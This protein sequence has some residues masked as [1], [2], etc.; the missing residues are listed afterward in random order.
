MDSNPRGGHRVNTLLSQDFAFPPQQGYMM[1]GVSLANARSCTSSITMF[2]VIE[3]QQRQTWHTCSLEVSV[4][5]WEL[6]ARCVCSCQN[7]FC[8]ITEKSGVSRIDTTLP[9]NPSSPRQNSGRKLKLY[10]SDIKRLL[11]WWKSCH[12]QNKIRRLSLKNTYKSKMSFCLRQIK[13]P[14]F[15]SPGVPVCCFKSPPHYGCPQW[16]S[17]TRPSPIPGPQHPLGWGR[18]S[19][20]F[21][22]PGLYQPLLPSDPTRHHLVISWQLRSSRHLSSRDIWLQVCLYSHKVDDRHLA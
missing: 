5:S 2:Y 18:S 6:C 15:L 17:W 10:V 20:C 21:G 1:E 22:V 16:K 12:W 19:A 9:S 14:F 4:K 7:C 11:K 3:Q 8:S 13:L